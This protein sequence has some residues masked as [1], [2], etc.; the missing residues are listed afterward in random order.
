[1]I[2][3]FIFVMGLLIALHCSCI[4][5]GSQTEDTSYSES[6]DQWDGVRTYDPVE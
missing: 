4:Y 3:A 2:G 6:E 1:M 5:V